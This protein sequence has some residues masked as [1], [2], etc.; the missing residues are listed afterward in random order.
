MNESKRNRLI[1]LAEEYEQKIAEA[2]AEQ[3]KRKHNVLDGGQ[4]GKVISLLMEWNRKKAEI[5]NEPE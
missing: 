3:E 4:P 2:D 1:A 5:I